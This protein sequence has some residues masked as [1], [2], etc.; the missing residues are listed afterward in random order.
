MIKLII[1]IVVILALIIFCI[2][3]TMSTN[4]I[5]KW[6]R[7]TIWTGIMFLI[8]MLIASIIYLINY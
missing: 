2:T 8:A 3:R 7:I 6:Q 1:F 5:S 4:S